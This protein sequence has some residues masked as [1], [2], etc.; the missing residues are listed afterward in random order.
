MS[1]SRFQSEVRNLMASIEFICCTCTKSWYYKF[2]IDSSAIWFSSL[3]QEKSQTSTQISTGE[4]ISSGKCLLEIPICECLVLFLTSFTKSKLMKTISAISGLPWNN[5]TPFA[6]LVQDE[7]RTVINLMGNLC[8]PLVP[9]NLQQNGIWPSRDKC[10]GER[11]INHV[12]DVKTC[13][14]LVLECLLSSRMPD[15]IV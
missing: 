7:N 11:P 8:A 13:V 2:W 6:V 5:C 15:T 1:P 14:G 10:Y 4:N 12:F 3:S 9:C